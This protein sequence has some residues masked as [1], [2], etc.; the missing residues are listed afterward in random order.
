MVQSAE[1]VLDQLW[2]QAYRLGFSAAA[3]LAGQPDLQ[4]DPFAIRAELN[5]LGPKW[6]GEIA[7]T[8]IERIAAVLRSGDEDQIANAIREV[9]NNAGDGELIAQTEITRAINLGAAAAYRAA[10]I[11][12][13][14]WLAGG[15]DPCPTCLTNQAAGPRPLGQPFPSGATAPPE[16]P[17]CRCALVP[18][19]RNVE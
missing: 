15:P 19:R 8:R 4:P 18:A 10:G 3:Q 1:S 6:A 9:L 7:A 14:E 5:R 12:E 16:H 13:V 2:E 11:P 17:R